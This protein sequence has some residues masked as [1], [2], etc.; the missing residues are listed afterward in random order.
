LETTAVDLTELTEDEFARF[1]DLV[2]RVSGIR[3]AP[4]KRVLLSNR[5]RRR[6]RATGIDGYSRYHDFLNSP[7]GK[8]E[9]QPFLDVVTTN[10]TY[11]FR[12]EAH[13]RWLAE[14][15]IPEAI[16][17]ARERRRPR[18]LRLWSAACSTGEEPYSMALKLAARRAE[19]AG[20]RLE[21]VGTDLSA[22][23]L[24]AAAAAVYDE[25]A[26]HR[27]GPEDRRAFFDEGPP[28]RWTV[29]P[30]V[31]SL[32]TF[33]RHNLLD[34]MPGEP[35]DCVFIKNVLIYFDAESKRKVVDVVVAALAKGGRLVVG[36]TEGIHNMLD[37]LEKVKTW[38]Y[39]K[40]G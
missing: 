40:G 22:T 12:D 6:L 14:E 37:G 16:Q 8:A 29:R 26:L 38:L 7:A 1:R 20:W 5:I 39:R 27:V 32:A 18:T 24:A 13:Y 28:G 10:E 17:E 35:F 11:F 34:R 30:A 2:Y 33:R 31:R 9:M 4:T 36:P 21:I 23:A 3:V 25:R 15:F 19:L